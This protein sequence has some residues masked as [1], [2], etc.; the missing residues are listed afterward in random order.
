MSLTEHPVETVTQLYS[1]ELVSEIRKESSINVEDLNVLQTSSRD[2]WLNLRK[3]FITASNVATAI[4]VDP[5]AKGN[6]GVSKVIRSKTLNPYLFRFLCSQRTTSGCQQHGL[7]MESV[8]LDML[9][10]FF[11]E[12]IHRDIGLCVSKQVPWLAATPDGM[13]TKMP[14]L[15]EVKCPARAK[16]FSDDIPISHFLQMQTQMFCTGVPYCLYAVFLTSSAYRHIEHPELRLDIVAAAPSF[17]REVIPKLAV[18]FRTIKR[19]ND[20][21]NG[22]S[23]AKKDA[24]RI[25]DLIENSFTAVPMEIEVNDDAG[26]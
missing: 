11:E 19:Y 3:N 7:D 9:E 15:V 23:K 2:E 22:R 1:D 16:K 6:Y 12:K 21:H 24:L 25:I 14:M 26:D 20:E 13:F 5:Y 18:V 8:V 17:K 10:A 4:G